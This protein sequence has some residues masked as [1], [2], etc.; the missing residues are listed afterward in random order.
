MSGQTS[1]LKKK[2]N[3]KITILVVYGIAKREN[4]IPLTAHV[5]LVPSLSC[6]DFVVYH[7]SVGIGKPLPARTA[8]YGLLSRM[9]THVNLRGMNK[10]KRIIVSNKYM[11]LKLRKSLSRNLI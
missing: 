2:T 11:H 5:T 7:Q 6:M 10:C 1:Y 4:I 9:D 8:D 3:I